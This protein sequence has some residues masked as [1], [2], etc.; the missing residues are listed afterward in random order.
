[1]RSSAKLV[2]SRFY[3]I[4][5]ALRSKADVP[6]DF[7]LPDD[8]ADFSS[9]VFLPG[10]KAGW[11]ERRLDPPRIVLL[12]K[13]CLAIVAHP[14][15]S[16]APNRIP[17]RNLQFIEYG[18]LLLVGWIS[19]AAAKG[20]HVLPFNTRTNG[21]VEQFLT[22][23]TNRLAQ[24]VVDGGQNNDF[25]SVG[26][27]LDIKFQNAELRALI[28][29]ERVLVRFFSPTRQTRSRAW[30]ILPIQSHDPADYMAVT[31][32]RLL[33][34]T[35]RNRGCY[36]PYGSIL[37][38]APLGNVVDLSVHHTGRNGGIV[39]RLGNGASWCIPLATDRVDDGMA[40][41]DHARARIGSLIL[42]RID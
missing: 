25:A 17:L 13:D 26:S 21:P 35:E 9:A 2:D 16:E 29:D 14:T 38:S 41:V 28:R 33:W 6:E 10:L 18:H 3:I 5:L 7:D 22:D 30:G 40:F 4:A 19:F 27:E 32:R 37:R 24:K 20:T 36:D 8:L 34:I 11:F 15:S 31:N 12:S 23:L 1:M 42:S 39:C